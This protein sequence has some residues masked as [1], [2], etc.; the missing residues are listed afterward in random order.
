MNI[1]VRLEGGLGDCLLGNRFV[2]AIKEKYPNSQI[3]AFID[4]EGKLFQK[5]GLEILYPSYYKEI[6]II[7][8]K[9]YKH[10]VV[11]TQFGVDETFKGSLDNVPDKYRKEMESYDKFYDLHIDSLKWLDYDFDW[12]RYIQFFP[13][14]E[15]IKK[16]SNG[17]N[18]AV[19]HLVS[20]TKND[21]GLEKF[22]INRLVE[23]TSKHCKVKLISTRDV[24]HFYSDLE[25]NPNVEILDVN[26]KDAFLAISAAKVMFSIDSGL[27]YVA[28]AYDIPT[29]CASKQVSSPMS[30]F[31]SHQVRWMPYPQTCFPLHYDAVHLSQIIKRIYN[32]KGYILNPLMVD[33]DSQIIK[34]NYK[35]NK[36][37]SIINHEN[38][39]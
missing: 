22:Y 1:C 4:S 31:F 19:F 34:R 17:E 8:Y 15:L 3:T 11:N 27:K 23:E 2:I 39:I 33:L 35:I 28:H 21:H 29:L 30:P 37:K 38:R 36:E 5:E 12:I 10:F 16:D 32:N 13:K 20:N 7:P 26:L 14:P 18:Y 24:R 25:N 6:K 9:K